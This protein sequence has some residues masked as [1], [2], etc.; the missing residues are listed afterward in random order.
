MTG[1]IAPLRNAL[2]R[3]RRDESGLALIEFAYSLP[4]L[5]VLG[6]GGIELA[7]YAITHMRVSQLA[8]SLAD[9][10]SRFK[11][12]LV[13]SNPI[14]REYDVEQAFMG[15]EKQASGLDFAEHG[16]MI[17]S[18]LER[19]SSGGQWIHWQRCAGEA[20]YSST[21]GE[22]DDGKYGTGMTGMGPPD[23]RVAAEQDY[24]IMF[25]E[26]FYDYQPIAFGELLPSGPIHKIAAMYVRDD[27]DLSKIYASPGVTPATCD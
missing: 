13:G 12:E 15:A 5:M 25:V 21:Y 2:H 10:S 22:E 1:L 27:R 3:L 17:L 14:I 19:N 7:N 20:P 9:N 24:A 26:V 23:R 11:E 18:S 8:I 6:L 4:I 16:R